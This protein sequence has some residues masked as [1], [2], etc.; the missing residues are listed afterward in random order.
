MKLRLAIANRAFQHP[1]NF[2]MFIT[3]HIVEDEDEPVAR[4]KVLDCSLERNTVQGAGKSQIPGT[5]VLVW[6]ILLG[7]LKCFFQGYLWEAFFPVVHQDSVHRQ[8][9][10]P[11]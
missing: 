10:Q 11:R 9:M 1:G 5:Q 4:W 2:I 6:T 7:R 8:T 3:L